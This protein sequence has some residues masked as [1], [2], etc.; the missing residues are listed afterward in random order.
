MKS[1]RQEKNLRLKKLFLIEFMRR[2]DNSVFKNG[3]SN[4]LGEF[5]NVDG[6]RIM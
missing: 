4:I 1:L 2:R 5:L 3:A 6:L